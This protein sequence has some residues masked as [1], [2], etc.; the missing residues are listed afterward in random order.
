M[1]RFDKWF[2]KEQPSEESQAGIAGLSELSTWMVR[3]DA[4]HELSWSR[5]VSGV[6][7]AEAK[8]LIE[9]STVDSWARGSATPVV[10]E[11]TADWIG[12]RDTKTAMEKLENVENTTD[13]ILGDARSRLGDP[14]FYEAS[15]IL[16]DV[17]DA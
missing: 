17:T 4:Q 15:L 3:L 10:S 7:L 1:S 9:V 11:I 2:N 6:R 13:A 8:E 16:L 14:W 12:V 5:L